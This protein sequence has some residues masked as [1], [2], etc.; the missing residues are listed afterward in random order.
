MKRRTR[1][2]FRHAALSLGIL[3][4]SNAFAAD[5][6]FGLEA[7]GQHESNVNRGIAGQELSDQS[8]SVEGYAA[9]SVMTGARSGFLARFGLRATAYRDFTDLSH[10]AALARFNWRFQP[11]AVFT[12]T[13]L[14]LSGSAEHRQHVDSSI[15][16]GQLVSIG[17]ALGKYFTDRLRLAGGVS[18][19]RRYGR[20]GA[21]YDLSNTRLHATA[22][23]QWSPALT[24]YASG[25]RIG[26]DQ[27]FTWGYYN[28]SS[29]VFSYNGRTDW[30]S[31]E[32]R[33]GTFDHDDR[34]YTAYRADATVKTFE[35]GANWSIDGG[36][37]I[38]VSVSR[39]DA[40]AKYG[41]SYDGYSVRAFYMM[42]FR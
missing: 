17:A 2:R 29:P 20:D 18:L 22:D 19:D 41:P 3:A 37:A 33:D 42:R 9:R 5:T 40:A 4:A 35:V 26:G 10:V 24:L 14:D 21:V 39:F 6:R 15:R 1:F 8:L 28:G 38:D 12:G 23:Y 31:A 27:V 11:N 30:W 36:H 34:R 32:A 13:W 7:G 16:D 25:A